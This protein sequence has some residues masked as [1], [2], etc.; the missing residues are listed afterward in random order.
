[1][2]GEEEKKMKGEKKRQD[3]TGKGEKGWRI[4]GEDGRRRV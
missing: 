4:G 1:M 2:R 3:E